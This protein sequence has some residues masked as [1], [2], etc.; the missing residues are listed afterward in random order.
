VVE[1]K[2][3]NALITGGAKRIGSAIA[4]RLASSGMNVV[5]HYNSSEAEAR[6]SV[7]ALSKAG[8]KAWEV[9]GELSSL[10]AAS[11]IFRRALDNAGPIDLLV[12]NASIFKEDSIRD[13]DEEQ[14]GMHISINSLAP[15]ALAREFAKQKRPGSIVNILDAR[16]TD[17]DSSHASYHLSKRMLADITAMLAIELAPL[18]RVNGVAPGLILPPPGKDEAYIE[19][20][21]RTNLL[22]SRGTPEDIA[23]AILF[24]ATSEFITGQV[25]Y[26]D[27][28]RH[29]KGRV[30][31]S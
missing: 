29:L 20:R 31:E 25:I 26:V 11:D 17:Y 30:Y 16:I 8:V 19:S 12:N 15:L 21:K 14:F 18:V 28:G 7:L 10:E 2:G 27:G 9:R 13:F 1:L 23:D 22:Q 3:K 4:S 5:L 24:L 6:A